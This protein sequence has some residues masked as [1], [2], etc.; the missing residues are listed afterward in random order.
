MRAL[1][2]LTA[3]QVK[4]AKP[5]KLSDGG[6]LWLHK[7]EDGGAQWVL[8]IT[9][10]GRRREMGLGPLKEVSLKDAREAADHWRSYVRRGLDPIKER[11]K[12]KRLAAKEVVTLEAV[13]FEA[14]EARKAELKGEGNAGR[15]FSPIKLHVL[16]VLGKMP[17]EDIDQRDVKNALAPLWH[18][19]AD[20]ARK[21]LN[22]LS[23]ILN[24]AAAMGL[25]VDVTATSKAKALLG[26]SRH[27]VQHI[28]S[29]DWRKVPEFYASLNEGS[30]VHLALRLLILTGLRSKPIRFANLNDISGDVWTVPAEMMKSLKG[31]EADFRVPLSKE[32]LSVIEQASAYERD[33]YI[34]PNVRR[35]VISD[36]TMSRFMERKGLD[37]RPH[38]FRT[39]FRTWMAEATDT[40]REVAETALSHV[41]GSK[42][43][44][45]YRRTDF[46]EQRRSVMRDWAAFTT[47]AALKVVGGA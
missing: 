37:E 25:D 28:P 42:V 7:R 3:L 1:Q 38:G 10:Y 23:I 16:P 26:K 24:H 47:G 43:E 5:G 44:R 46:L 11:E 20:T 39:S 19:K 27:Q 22:R 35:G 31:F 45:T 41:V 12:E 2:K 34:F 17:V 14:F 21:S 29:L 4:N 32:A 8:R 6:G 36:A 18:V 15:W 30:V 33:G 9:V 13:A 40:P